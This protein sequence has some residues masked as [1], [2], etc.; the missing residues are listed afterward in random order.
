MH[1]YKPTI[2]RIMPSAKN[3][4]SGKADS[5]LQQSCTVI[6]AKY[7]EED[8]QMEI[9][10]FDFFELPLFGAN[11]MFFGA[12]LIKRGDWRKN[13][14]ITRLRVSHIMIHEVSTTMIMKSKP[15]TGGYKHPMIKACWDNCIIKSIFYTKWSCGIIFMKNDFSHFMG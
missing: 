2:R 7:K 11:T 12:Y 14:K 13:E 5:S 3:E 8:V 4:C 10:A 6:S 9:A 15:V 1:P